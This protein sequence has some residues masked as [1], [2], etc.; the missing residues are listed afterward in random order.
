MTRIAWF[1]AATAGIAGD[2]ALAA[3]LDAGA[4]LDEVVAA[5]RSLGVADWT[6][7]SEAVLRAGLAATRVV[8]EVTAPQHNH[9]PAREVLHILDSADGLSERTH[10]RAR[11]TFEL[12][13]QVEGALHGVDPD[14]VEFHEV[15]AIDSIVDVVGVCVALDLLDIDEVYASPVA[16]GV[17]VI[18]SAHGVLPN[19]APAVV[20]LLQGK[21]VV[22][23][24]V[25][26]E[27]TTPTGAA[28]LAANALRFGPMPALTVEA[29][30]YGAGSR[31]L[32]G[33][34]N[35][36]QVLI[37]SSA[38][39]S[40][41]ASVASQVTVVETTVD[42][43]SGEVLGHTVGRLLAEGAL[44]AW[45]APVTMKKGRPGHTITV[46]CQPTDRERLTGVLLAE[47]GSLGARAHQVERTVLSRRHRVV[48][49][50]GQPV[51]VK[52]GPHRAKA[53]YEDAALVAAA[54]G[55]TI[56]AVSEA[57]E[58][59]AAAQSDDGT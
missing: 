36:T 8:V 47:T 5:C 23:V 17:G 49:V 39:T 26:V 48:E 43:V 35:V 21:P 37:G 54:T 57:A 16:Q 7:R 4:S 46:L 31:D 29:S 53:E 28:L 19:P 15:G 32:P 56:R 13:A 22:G 41:A 34:A 6:M 51:R 3:L 2:M 30:G 59:L 11:A 9:R 33:R 24:D 1:N 12:L 18:R 27:L 44:D 20:R 25:T 14:E 45:T 40:P 42:D 52:I 55:L 38:A 50:A 10:R 58:R